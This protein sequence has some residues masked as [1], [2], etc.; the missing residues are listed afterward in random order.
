[1]GKK[2]SGGKGGT[3]GGQPV[4]PATPGGTQAPPAGLAKAAGAIS[5]TSA[6]DTSQT[7]TEEFSPEQIKQDESLQKFNETLRKQQDEAFKKQQELS[8]DGNQ[9]LQDQKSQL[10]ALKQQ[11]INT[12]LF[13]TLR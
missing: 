6:V 1:M 12:P 7:A 13:G 4:S 3:N 5:F 8:R 2:R 9:A 10:S 11:G